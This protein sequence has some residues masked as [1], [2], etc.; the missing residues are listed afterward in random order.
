MQDLDFFFLLPK[1]KVRHKEI[2]IHSFSISS[3]V[4]SDKGNCSLFFLHSQK[5]NY[6][7]PLKEEIN[8]FQGIFYD[9]RKRNEDW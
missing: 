9:L 4:C 8:H 2:F 7:S 3:S 5:M 6:H 1:L